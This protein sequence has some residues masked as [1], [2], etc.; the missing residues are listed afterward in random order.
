MFIFLFKILNPAEGTNAGKNGLAIISSCKYK[1]YEGIL[2][3]FDG[4]KKSY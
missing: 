4:K 1:N 3:I 2:P